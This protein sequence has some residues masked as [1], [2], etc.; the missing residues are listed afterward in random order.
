M[1]FFKKHKTKLI[2][3]I[4][5]LAVGGFV[6]RGIYKSKLAPKA[7]ETAKVEIRQIEETL[8]ASG[9][10]E[11]VSSADLAF[12]AFGTIT[13]VGVKEGDFVKQYQ[14][15]ARVDA[16]TLVNALT[17]AEIAYQ[18]AITNLDK[19]IEAEGAVIATYRDTQE[20]DYIRSQKAQYKQAVD[21]ARQS[22]ES[23]QISVNTAKK[24]LGETAIISPILG[25]ITQVN[26]TQGEEATATTGTAIQVADLS[27]FT[28]AAEVDEAE[29]SKVQLGQKAKIELNAYENTEFEAVVTKIGTIATTDSSGNKVFDIELAIQS[30]ENL[31]KIGLEGDAQIV[32]ASANALSIPW[33]A[34]VLEDDNAYVFVVENGV[35]VKKE[36]KLGLQS[37]EYYEISD[38]LSANETVIINPN[39][40]ICEGVKVVKKS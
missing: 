21:A 12:S 30:N 39:E 11:A 25:T 37:S 28:F 8:T 16:T 24:N 29:I 14:A 33:E 22:V 1:S 3:I 31:L 2:I 17:T 7:V 10:V 27:T 15:L 19:A 20:T 36:V 4:I 9:E 26:I 6:A 32:T 35:A 23:A 5:L 34:V 40:N 13:W 38:G 18:T